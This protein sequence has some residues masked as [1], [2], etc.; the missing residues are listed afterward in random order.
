MMAQIVGT[1]VTMLAKATAPTKD[2]P[3]DVFPDFSPGIR[4]AL[5]GNYWFWIALFAQ[6]VVPIEFF[7]FFR[8]GQLSKP[9]STTHIFNFW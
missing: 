6:L 9:R 7:K 3:G 2:G 4:V 1:L 8:K 5:H